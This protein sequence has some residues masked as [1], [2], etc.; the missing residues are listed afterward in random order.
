[1]L[2]GDWFFPLLH[3]DHG[4]CTNPQKSG[5]GRGGGVGGGG[6][7]LG[8]DGVFGGVSVCMVKMFPQNKVFH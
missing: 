4:V 8:C 7:E 6:G 5:P 2:I 1:M 3:T